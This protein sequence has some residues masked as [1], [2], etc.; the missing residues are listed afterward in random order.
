MN[1]GQILETH[2]GWASVA[3]GKKVALVLEKSLKNYHVSQELELR[4]K[5]K[6]VY[7]IQEKNSKKVQ[8]YVDELKADD[9]LDLA[10]DISKGIKFA[11]PVFDGA[12]EEHINSLLEK[13]GLEK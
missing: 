9:L 12:K 1:I 11:T 6:E 2:L 8:N 10:Q 3:L 13:A 7:E 4:E 5:I